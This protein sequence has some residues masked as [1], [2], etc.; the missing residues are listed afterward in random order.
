MQAMAQVA[1]A[2]LVKGKDKMNLPFNGDRTDHMVKL[3][4][5]WVA[6]VAAAINWYFIYD[7]ER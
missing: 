4:W 5:L 7:K 2:T 6:V 1:A 3:L